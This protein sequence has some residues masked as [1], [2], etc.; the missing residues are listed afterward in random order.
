[1]NILGLSCYYHDGAACLVRD[2]NV[3]AA[4]EEERFTRIKHDSDFP[5]RAINFCLDYAKI[6]KQDIDYVVFY[7]KPFL[8]LERLLLNILQT[9][10]RSYDYFHKTVTTWFINK[11]WIKSHIVEKLNIKEDKILFIPHHLS[12]AASAFL[13]SGFSKAAILTNDAVGEW[14]TSA[15]GIG[16]GE[17]ITMLKEMC[18]PH[19][20]GLLYATLT[21]FLGFEV[22]EGEFKVMG[23]AGFGKPNYVKEI[24]KIF[25]LFGDG[26]I[27]LNLEYFDFPNSTTRMFSDKLV[28]LLGKPRQPG[29]PFF[30]SETGYPSYYDQKPDNYKVL[31]SDNQRY[32]DLAA[33]L[34]KVTEE[35]ILTQVRYIYKETKTD[36]LCLAGGVALNGVANGRIVNETPIKK[37]FIQPAAGDSGG[38]MGAA[39]FAARII[40]KEKNKFTLKNCYLGPEFG[41]KEIITALKNHKLKFKKYQRKELLKKTVGFIEQGKVVGWFQGRLEWG[42][43]ALGNR[44]IIADARRPDM[45]DIINTKIKFREPF[46]PFAP[47]VIASKAG[48]YF[49]LPDVENSL[50]AKFMTIVCNIKKEKQKEI[51]AVTHIDKTGRLQVIDRATNPLYFDIVEKFGKETGTYVLINTSFNLK[52][53]PIVCTPEDAISTYLRSG[54]DALVLGNY[55]TEK[56]VV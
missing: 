20:V 7:E 9:Y 11:L 32:A 30:T 10:P 27:K 41:N 8:K 29:L 50:P 12:H 37:L 54:I 39:L 56:T 45:K 17:S 40:F 23:M 13:P 43:R 47:V 21:A 16:D 1:M 15:F 5:E 33:S 24:Q 2:G 44:S 49:D 51:P 14:S 34:Q 53:E 4:A 46:R 19:S 48:D 18:Y 35:I 25:T 3:I 38:A 26:S 6:K 36:N 42:P 52:G 22:N 31:A 28:S 55:I